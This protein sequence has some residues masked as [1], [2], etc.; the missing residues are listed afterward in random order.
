MFKLKERGTTVPTELMAGVT[1]FLT[2]VYIV[3]VN[4]GILS[5][6]GM[7]FHGVFIATV[8]ASI[9]ATLIMG[10]FA[11]YPIVLA[12]GMGLN[13]YFAFSVVGGS[14]VSWQTALGAVF[15][16][17]VLFIV[18]SLTSF[19]YMLLDA[20]PTSLKHAITAGIG[21]FITFIGLQNA[22]VIVA[23]P[24]TLLTLGDLREPMTALTIIGLIVSLILM[25]YQV[26]GFLFFGMLITAVLAWIM[27]LLTMPEAFIAA[28]TGLSATA[29]QLDIS[30]VFSGGMYA[31]IFTFLL[32]TLF[33]TTGTMLGVAEQ[34][35]LL[36]DN[37]FP[38]SRGALLADAIG[39]ST[40]ALLGTSP[41]S[42][43]IESSSGVA[44]GGRTGLTA[45]TVCVLLALTLFFSPII[46]VLASIPAITAPALIIVGFL[47]MNVLRKIEWQDLEEAFPAFLIVVL[48]PL[49][50]SIATGIGIGFIVYP[51]LKLLRGKRSDVHPIFYL[52]AV[53]F[54]IQIV[55]FSH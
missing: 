39:T 34:A 35:G 51:V 29:F 14:G 33:D 36:K 15:V 19:R 26:R 25:A 46:A 3:I 16:A 22:K 18:L 48:M 55:F 31:V 40:G 44:V 54:F 2:M 1:T 52:F 47:M 10:L 23:S 49:T 17:G 24:S 8:L 6:A 42:A 30:G 32:I 37:K 21:L 38:R 13:A 27:G 4:P 9:V 12:P 53:L 20:I 45:I 50:Y 11:N 7:D 28:P 41:T 5:K 43:Y